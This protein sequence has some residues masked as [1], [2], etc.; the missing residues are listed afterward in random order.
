MV[1]LSVACTPTAYE[2]P[3]ALRY[4][5]AFLRGL[6]AHSGLAI[7]DF[8]APDEMDWLTPDDRLNL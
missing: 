6:G 3:G 8:H 2:F 5:C 4:F 7:L 1:F